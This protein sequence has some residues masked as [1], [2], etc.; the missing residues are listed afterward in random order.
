MRPRRGPD[1]RHPL[2]GE[3]VGANELDEFAVVAE[4]G[5]ER[6]ATQPNRAPEDRIENRLASVGELEIACK[7]ALVAVC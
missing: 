3:V 2:L 1:L 5:A 4:D 6:A 7:T